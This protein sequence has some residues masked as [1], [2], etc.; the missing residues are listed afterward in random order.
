MKQLLI[1]YTPFQFSVQQINES[2][3]AGGPLVVS[4]ILQR[5]ES[6]NHN[7]RVYPREILEREVNRYSERYV[8]NRNALGE[9]DHPDSS[10]VN[11]KNVSHNIREVKFE[12][13]DVIGV[14]EILSTPSGNILKELFKH[15]ITIGI[16]SRGL[17][18]VKQM[19]EGTVEVQSDFELVAWDFVSNPSTQGA[20][21]SPMNESIS[22]GIPTSN[23]YLC[24][25]WCKSQ[26]IMRRILE[27]LH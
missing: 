10:V 23:E 2:V 24:N 17:G 4:G 16:S 12:G 22:N 18:S 26:D 27:E 25:E 20:Y 6:K 1:D 19:Q 7:G 8:K 3:K 21:M 9:L 13:N 5:A 11:L 14:I 15:N